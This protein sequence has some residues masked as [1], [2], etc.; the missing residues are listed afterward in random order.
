MEILLKYGLLKIG[1]CFVASNKSRIPEKDLRN[2]LKLIKN[3]YFYIVS[4]WR[5]YYGTENIKFYC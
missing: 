5:E 3:H 4:R 1:D 2:I